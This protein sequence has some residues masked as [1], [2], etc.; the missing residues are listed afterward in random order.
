MF[1]RSNT[2]IGGDTNQVVLSLGP[3]NADNIKV[4]SFGEG[5]QNPAQPAVTR[6][7]YVAP[8]WY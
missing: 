8:P 6:G 1:Y 3:D 5:L 7:K 2:G 4:I